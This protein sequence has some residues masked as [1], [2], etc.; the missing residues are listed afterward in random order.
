MLA[1]ITARYRVGLRRITRGYV[2][3]GTHTLDIL[4]A[5][6]GNLAFTVNVR[7]PTKKRL[8]HSGIQGEPGP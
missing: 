7:R 6:C 1:S 8:D 4:H 5:G 2:K 3:I